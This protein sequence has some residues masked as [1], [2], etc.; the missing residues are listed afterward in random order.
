VHGW[1]EVLDQVMADYPADTMYIFGHAE[2][3]FPFSGTR[4][5]LTY[6]KSYFLTIIDTAQ[7]G[8]RAGQSREQVI[9]LTTL[10]GFEHFGGTATRLG[11]A[12][13]I[14][15]DELAARR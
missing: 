8:L 2:A 13:G 14:A 12:L 7:R 3:G 6:Q 9:G 4:E 11:L 15:Y 1:V 10:P 5:D